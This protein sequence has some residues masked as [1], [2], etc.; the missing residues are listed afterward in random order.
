[1][2]PQ[3]REQ[4]WSGRTVRIAAMN[5]GEQAQRI[6]DA[7]AYRAYQ[8]FMARQAKP[9]HQLD[10][11]QRAASEIVRP[12]DS[13]FVILDDKIS[14]NID[15][16]IFGEGPI[17][18]FPQ[19]RRLI[20]GGKPRAPQEGSG[21]GQDHPSLQEDRIYGVVELPVETDPSQV[22]ARF[23]GPILEIELARAPQKVLPWPNVA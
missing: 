17:E 2:K 5:P 11:W 6:Q 19:P 7:V 23:N 10:D 13:G 22:T 3:M 15:I 21:T 9:D 8:Y 14:L 4:S 12:L 16:R 20:I 1:M 18:V